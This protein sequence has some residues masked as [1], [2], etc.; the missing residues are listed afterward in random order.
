MAPTRGSAGSGGNKESDAEAEFRDELLG[1]IERLMSEKADLARQLEESRQMVQQQK[2]Q[3]DAVRQQAQIDK[4]NAAAKEK[5]EAKAN[6]NTC[7]YPRTQPEL[8]L[9]ANAILVY[10]H[11]R[12]VASS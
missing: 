10:M 12:L 2:K 1:K 7:K 9:G 4:F 5:K 8:A 6:S 3:V 11:Y